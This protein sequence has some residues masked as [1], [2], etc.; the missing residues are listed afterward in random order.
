MSHSA[1]SRVVVVT[2]EQRA[3][4]RKRLTALLRHSE[5]WKK[6]EWCQLFL[7]KLIA[8]EEL[9]P[10][11]VANAH[12]DDPCNT[13]FEMIGSRMWWNHDWLHMTPGSVGCALSHR[14]IWQ[15]LLAEGRDDECGSCWRMTCYG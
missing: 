1:P 12:S 11:Y 9:V 4:R 13:R 2:L 8:T 15:S 6:L 10:K 3:D 5:L 7:A 14:A